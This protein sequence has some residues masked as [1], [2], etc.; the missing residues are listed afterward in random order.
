MTDSFPRQKARTRDFTLGEPRSFEVAADGSRVVFLRSPAGDDPQTALWVFD[1]AEQRERPVADPTTI[2]EDGRA[3][4]LS[5]AERARR[6]RS[7]ET[8]GGIVSYAIDRNARIAALAL[9]GKL[10]VADLIRGGATRLAV[11]TPVFDPRP[12]P[13]GRRVAFVHERS[14]H[15]V[16]LAD[17]AVTRLAGEEQPDVSW[18]VAEFVAA[19]EMHRDRG[20][21]WSPDGDALLATRVDE[22]AVRRLW[23]SDVAQPGSP[24]RAVRYPTAG[25]PNATVEAYLLRLD[26][27]KPLPVTWDRDAYPYLVA[28]HWDEHGAL[29]AVQT[30]D[31]RELVVLG[32]DSQTGATTELTTQTDDAWVDV[33][34]GVPRR[35]SDGRLV[36]VGAA[37]DAVALLIDGSPVTPPDLE[38]R[39][40]LVVADDEVLF[41]ASTEPTEVGVWRWDKTGDLSQLTPT[42]GVHTAAAGGGV[43]VIGSS[44]MDHAGTRWALAGHVFE[45]RAET[46]LLSPAIELLTV[47]PRQLRVGMVLPR[48]HEPGSRLPVL[49]DPYGGPHFLRVQ[50]ARRLWL[51]PQWLADQGFAV[52][53]ADGRGTP[54]RGRAWAH[55]VKG[56]LAAPAL[57]DQVAALGEV[58]ARHPEL[59][60]TQVA[61]RGW[62]F[63]GYLA[64]LAVLHRPDVFHAAVAGAPVTEWR[65]YDTFYTERYLGTDPDGANRSAYDGSS[66]LNDAAKL[67]RPLL[68]IHGFADDNVLTAHTLQLSQ[69]LTESG[70]LHSV[71]PLTGITHMTPQEAV[72]ENLLTLQVE[73]LKR[74]LARGPD[75]T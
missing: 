59:D 32:V 24:P 15:A 6:E 72:A 54:A 11:P 3:E 34:P 68:L 40:A 22:S 74:A 35:L 31:Q 75:P 47:G 62:S 43:R 42:P 1:V 45:S 2:L 46:P 9:S 10:L 55:S 56:D 60:L 41:T 58:A 23:I 7:R 61:I 52:I 17:G 29:V 37:G 39:A 8:G 64:A 12:D 30:R 69:R 63:G 70:R 36:M 27:T 53:V 5:Q 51:E 33:L 38:V 21:W 57:E 14:L 20:Y 16:E 48:D 67:R 66:L 26:G 65:L 71:L 49:M 18:G 44:G 28:A 50:K 13:T 73:F 25:S 19:E 4:D